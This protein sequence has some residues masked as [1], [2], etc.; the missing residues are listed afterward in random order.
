MNA[1]LLQGKTPLELFRLYAFELKAQ[2]DE[3]VQAHIDL[4]DMMFDAHC[5]GDFAPLF[6]A[7]MAAHLMV[8]PGG[9]A[10]SSNSSGG[11]PNGIKSIKEGDLQITYTDAGSTKDT[12]ALSFKAW[13]DLSRF[14]QLIARL[15][16]NMG[17]GH[18]I[19]TRGPSDGFTSGGYH[20]PNS[21]L[22]VLLGRGR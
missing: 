12:S 3:V 16:A 15:R 14:G 18:G 19:M 9:V 4:A 7:L 21:Q 13:L 2:P 1:A 6:L 5:Y 22:D 20:F 11:G 17:L 8:I 10:A